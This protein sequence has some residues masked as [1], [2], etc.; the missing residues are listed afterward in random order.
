MLYIRRLR[1]GYVNNDIHR[2]RDRLPRDA[3][4]VKS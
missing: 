2:S 1:A 3:Q 4:T